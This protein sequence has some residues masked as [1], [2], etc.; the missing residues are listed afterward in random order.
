L[1]SREFIDSACDLLLSAGDPVGVLSD[2]Q[3]PAPITIAVVF[4]DLFVARPLALVVEG[5]ETDD[6][7]A[8][9]GGAAA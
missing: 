7:S 1:A 9:A 8:F 3:Q 6:V 5:T 2:F 4:A